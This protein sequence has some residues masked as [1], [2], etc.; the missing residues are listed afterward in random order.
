MR[1]LFAILGVLM[2]IAG[3]IA[4]AVSKTMFGEISGLVAWV[5]AAQLIT[6]AATIEAILS[7][8]PKPPA[9]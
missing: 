7:L 9:Q 8:R 4:L 2:L 1:V 6:A 5:I 3:A